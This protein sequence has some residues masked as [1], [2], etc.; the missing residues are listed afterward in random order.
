MNV[1]SNLKQFHPG[2]QM[3]CLSNGRSDIV[4]IKRGNGP[5][6]VYTIHNITENKIN[7]QLNDDDLSELNTKDL[8]MRDLLTSIKYNWKNISLDP[9]KVI[10]LGSL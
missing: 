7:Y 6:S 3:E 4:V 8:S 9:F 10:W 5:K 1:R 2:S